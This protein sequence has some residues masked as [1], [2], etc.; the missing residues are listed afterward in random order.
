MGTVVPTSQECYGMIL[1]VNLA[2]GSYSIN[3][4]FDS[5]A[6]GEKKEKPRRKGGDIKGGKKNK[7]SKW[8]AKV[9]VTFW[10]L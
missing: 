4:S 6:L 2:H 1:A 3:M 7:G 10:G 9:A 5:P 8:T